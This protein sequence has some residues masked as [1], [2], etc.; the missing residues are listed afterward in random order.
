MT[1][2]ESLVDSDGRIVYSLDAG[3]DAYEVKY[4]LDL[5]ECHWSI[6]GR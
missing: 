1:Q 5:L 3:P 2:S 6:S 4:A